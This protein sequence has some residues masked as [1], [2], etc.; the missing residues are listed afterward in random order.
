MELKIYRL[1]V[2]FLFSQSWIYL[3]HETDKYAQHV[4]ILFVEL[5]TTNLLWKI[6][7]TQTYMFHKQNICKFAN[8]HSFY[9]DQD[10]LDTHEGVFLQ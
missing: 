4:N 9:I 5:Y 10:H 6:V 1:Y 2:D 7:L 3:I 8:A